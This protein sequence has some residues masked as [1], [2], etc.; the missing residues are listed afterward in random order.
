MALLQMDES[1]DIIKYAELI[2]LIRSPQEKCF[3][4]HYQFC[5]DIPKQA[6]ECEILKTI[7]E[8]QKK[9]IKYCVYF[10]PRV[11]LKNRKTQRFCFKI[12][13]GP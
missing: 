5:K 4:E 12:L 10:V 2:A 7:N 1:A 6:T 3:I 11:Q 8:Y 13:W 9:G